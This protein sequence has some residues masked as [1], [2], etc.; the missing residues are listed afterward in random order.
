MNNNSEKRGGVLDYAIGILTIT[1]LIL[2]TFLMPQGYSAIIDNNDLNMVHVVE[3]ESFSFKSP[4]GLTVRERIQQMMESIVKKGVLKRTLYLNGQEVTDGELLVGVREAMQIAAQY[5]L[6][7]DISAYDIE[8]NIIYAEYYNLSD[9]TAENA[10]STKIAFW[11][12]RFS[13]YETFDF[14]F[15]VDASEYIIY[16]AELYCGEVADYLTQLMSDDKEVTA[17]LNGQFIEGCESYLESEG[18]DVMTDVSYGDMALMLGYER[19]E[20]ALYRAHCA[21][22]YIDGDGIRW[23]FVPMTIA[24]EKSNAAKDWGYKGIEGYYRDLYH[25]DIYEEATTEGK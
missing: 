5:N 19:G 16:Q 18:Y 1:I 14:T 24:L 7:P 8:N 3:R 2:A 17:F 20:Y 11:N 21:N 12:I 6:L 15:R 25:I 10:E 22:G 13:D 23:G 9:S 4:V